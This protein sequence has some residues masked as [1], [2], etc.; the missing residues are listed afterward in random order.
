MALSKPKAILFDWDNTLVDT[1]P[2]IHAALHE[3]FL[4]LNQT[5]WTMEQVQA[6]VKKSMRDSF[7]EVFG[8]DWQLAAEFYQTAYRSRNL[9]QLKPLDGA[10]ET[11][12][13]LLDN[14]DYY[15]AVVS[16]KKGINLRQEVEALGWGKYFKAL[17]GADDAS[18]DKPHKA[19]VE[20]ALKDSGVAAGADVWFVGDSEID[21]ECAQNTGCVGILYGTPDGID[22][23]QFGGFP[24]AAHGRDQAELRAVFAS[25]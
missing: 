13:W 11:L 6:R 1:W 3:T 4:K 9:T 22:G 23:K 5:P 15:V 19:P 2:I 7:P 8:A 10:E 20:L 14:T 21:M 25:I 18:H 24:Y 16:N 12:R 17:V